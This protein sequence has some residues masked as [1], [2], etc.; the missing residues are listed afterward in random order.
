MVQHFAADF[1]QEAIPR[2]NRIFETTRPETSISESEELRILRALYRFQL[3]CNIFG[4]KTIDAAKQAPPTMEGWPRQPW[5]GQ[6]PDDLDC[7]LELFF[8]PWPPWANEQLACVFEYLE[9]KISVYF[10]D[11]ASHDID[12]GRRQV[13]R[14][15][16]TV[17]IPY[18]QFLVSWFMGPG[19]SR[20]TLSPSSEK[21]HLYALTHLQLLNGLNLPYQLK[22]SDTFEAWTTLLASA[23]VCRTWH[24]NE[25]VV[26][27]ASSLRKSV[28]PSVAKSAKGEPPTFLGRYDTGMLQ[29]LE[30]RASWTGIDDA[31]TLPVTLWRDA[32]Y[33]RGPE[34]SVIGRANLLLRDAGYVFWDGYVGETMEILEW[35]EAVFWTFD[36]RLLPDELPR[37]RTKMIRSWERR[38]RIWEE[39]G[40]GYWADGDESRVRYD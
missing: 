15:E 5:P 14:V 40:R 34:H 11:V 35:M 12:W 31:E 6:S 36:G 38:R 2:F 4:R 33:G 29:A 3:Y 32:Y 24:A 20:T 37:L 27:M 39:G 10:N 7:E 17:A 23:D 9:T 26:T 16:P 25:P 18:R 30:G 21:C 19:F 22:Q 28:R 13:N 8:W 1:P